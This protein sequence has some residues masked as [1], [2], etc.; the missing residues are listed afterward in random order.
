MPRLLLTQLTLFDSVEDTWRSKYCTGCREVKK[1]SSFY[2]NKTNKDG[3]DA[4]CEDCRRDILTKKR[5]EQRIEY[6][7]IEKTLKRGDVS[8]EGLI[9]WGYDLLAKNFEH[10]V[11][12]DRFKEK[13]N[14]VNKSRSIRYQEDQLY[15]LRK[16][17]SRN[18]NKSLR[19]LNGSKNG[20]SQ[21]DIMGISIVEFKKYLS[22]SFLEGMS[23]ENRSEWHID[24]ILPVSA[25]K[26]QEEMKMLW[27]YTNMRPMWAVDNMVKGG[28]HCPFELE[29]FFKRRRLEMEQS[30]KK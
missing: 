14:T 15:K 30:D 22:D 9:F 7:K 23:W 11:D 1:I 3:Y 17:L 25:A 13:I 29:E 28:K 24:H 12:K 2:K 18:L 6:E 26:T 27:H 10:W 4:R 20:Q 8:P 21:C 16:D 19:K 5:K